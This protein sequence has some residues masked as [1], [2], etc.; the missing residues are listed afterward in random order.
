M[1]E[2]NNYKLSTV[3]SSCVF[4]I[5]GNEVA[6]KLGA[7]GGAALTRERYGHVRE[8]KWHQSSTPPESQQA[9]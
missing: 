3:D 2:F 4:H 9:A 5:N 8:A 6:L 1:M 7:N